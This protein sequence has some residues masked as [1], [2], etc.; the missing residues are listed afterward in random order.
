M[1]KISK[2]TRDLNNKVIEV[3]AQVGETLLFF[4]RRNGKVIEYK[5]RSCQRFGR[6]K[7]EGNYVPAGLHG[8]VEKQVRAI[9]GEIK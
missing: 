7:P 9:F 4:A 6:A 8:R 1:I 5:P 2:V 3:I